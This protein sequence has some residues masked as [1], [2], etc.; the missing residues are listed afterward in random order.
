MS[1]EYPFLTKTNFPNHIDRQVEWK[2][3]SAEEIPFVN[4]YNKDNA[5]KH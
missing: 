2:D 5:K 3:P 1:V 4:K